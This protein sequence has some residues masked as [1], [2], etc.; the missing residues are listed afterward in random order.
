MLIF[1]VYLALPFIAGLLKIGNR[2]GPKI[3]PL[4]FHQFAYG[5][6]W[7]K[8]S[9]GSDKPR[10]GWW[11]K[12]ENRPLFYGFYDKNEDP[13]FYQEMKDKKDKEFEEKK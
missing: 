13:G 11:F 5:M 4:E 12:P 2:W 9:S 7:L 1:F 6:A 10:I 8:T 3:Y